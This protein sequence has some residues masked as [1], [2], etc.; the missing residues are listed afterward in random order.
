[1]RFSNGKWNEGL[2]DGL[3]GTTH[4]TVIFDNQA[5]KED[6][7][8]EL[9]TCITAYEKKI[10]ELFDTFADVHDLKFISKLLRERE[11]IKGLM[12]TTFSCLGLE[13]D[14]VFL[15]QREQGAGLFL[16]DG[17]APFSNSSAEAVC[18]ILHRIASLS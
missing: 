8:V 4:W 7:L 12:I 6:Y 9:E 2:C 10:F 15:T 17:P 11:T 5:D 14:Y 16:K 13:F 18:S 1:M 3:D